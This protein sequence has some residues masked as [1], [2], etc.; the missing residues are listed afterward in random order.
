VPKSFKICPVKH[1]DDSGFKK[2]PFSLRPQYSLAEVPEAPQTKIYK[3]RDAIQLGDFKSYLIEHEHEVSM[4]GRVNQV[5]FAR[6]IRKGFIH[7]YHSPSQSLALLTGKKDDILDFC[8]VTASIPEIKIATIAIDMK[9]LLAKLAEVKLVWFRFPAGMIH[10]SALM[11][12]HLEQTAD[13]EKAKAEGDIS[14]LSFY[15]QDKDKKVHPIMVTD[16]GAV[17]LQDLYQSVA[18]EVELV[19]HV[20]KILL[21][22]I[23]REET[24]RAVRRTAQKRGT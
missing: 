20:K 6:F 23:H 1:F 13:F 24:I 11:G 18:D 2:Q 8:K 3:A 7:A 9:A 22:G 10:A 5:S 12:S 14:T 4:Y 19:L 21:D 16:D 17:V 15:V